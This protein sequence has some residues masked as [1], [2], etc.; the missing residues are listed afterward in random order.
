[1]LSLRAI[2]AD[3]AGCC[4]AELLPF[5]VQTYLTI[6]S[7]PP[8]SVSL[9]LVECTTRNFPYFQALCKRTLNIVEALSVKHSEKIRFYLSKADEAGHE[10]DR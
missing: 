6:L 3:A 4:H 9:G 2:A 1:M 10:S 8:P 5:S 7:S